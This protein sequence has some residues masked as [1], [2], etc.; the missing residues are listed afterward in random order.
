MLVPPAVGLR[1]RG[2]AT[3]CRPGP[4]ALRERGRSRAR[5]RRWGTWIRT[6]TSVAVSRF[7]A[8]RVASY[9]IPHRVAYGRREPNPETARFELARYASSRH[10]RVR[11]LGLEP[12]ISRLRVGCTSA[13]ACSAQSPTGES[14]SAHHFGGVAHRRNA[15]RARWIPVE[16][17]GIEPS[18][19]RLQGAA[20]TS[21]T[22]P[23]VARPGWRPAGTCGAS[24]C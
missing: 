22:H 10:T 3:R 15:C 6:R 18:R 13:C 23:R 24:R 17:L 21:A 9:T 12:R 4:P 16:M 5:R 2:A 20:A 14:N 8:G 1:G 7:R 19:Q 11:R